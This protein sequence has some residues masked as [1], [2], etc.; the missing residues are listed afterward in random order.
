MSHTGLHFTIG[1]APAPSPS[2]KKRK[3]AKKKGQPPVWLGKCSLCL[4][5]A[6]ALASQGSDVDHSLRKLH[7]IHVQ[8]PA[9]LNW[10]EMLL[11]A[12]SMNL[13]NF[14]IECQLLMLATR[15]RLTNIVHASMLQ[16]VIV[17]GFSEQEAYGAL[18]HYGCVEQAISHLRA[19]KAPMMNP[20][21]PSLLLHPLP[22]ATAPTSSP[23][24][25]GARTTT[26]ETKLFSQ[27]AFITA[28][29]K[30][31]DASSY[32]QMYEILPHIHMLI[33]KFAQFKGTS[34]ESIADNFFDKLQCGIDAKGGQ[35][36]QV[37]RAVVRIWS[38]SAV[39][40]LD[41]Q[42][43][44]FCT[45]LNSV[46]RRDEMGDM[47]DH[48]A[49][50]SR[51]INRVCVNQSYTAWPDGPQQLAPRHSD[52]R[53]T[54]FR[55]GGIRKDVLPWFQQGKKYRTN[56]FVATSFYRSVA[57]KFQVEA[58]A[59]QTLDPIMWK[60]Q[61]E[62]E[63]CL[64]VNFLRPGIES[65]HS[66]YEFLLPPGTVLTVVDLVWRGHATGEPHEITVKVAPDNAKEPLDLPLS[67]WC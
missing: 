12:S 26:L 39:V 24:T 64:H 45:I 66:E 55:G 63:N 14:E 1:K 40:K 67:P 47:L 29:N 51:A 62:H 38:S 35:L 30:A 20:G 33:R 37:G 5:R 49:V 4:Q 60:F 53:D 50:I 42:E 7:D 34:S 58:G 21:T 9:F 59:S 15:H 31:K 3:S 57:E 32:K 23:R 8:A 16:Q 28:Y 27:S 44:E 17:N 61:F 22:P 13:Q 41:G 2:D 56:M 36:A 46:L 11:S 25:G 43:Y 10:E 48:A 18:C 65:T 52:E 19:S 6:L 54:T